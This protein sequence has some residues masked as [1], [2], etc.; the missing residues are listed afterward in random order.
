MTY[1]DWALTIAAV[2]LVGLAFKAMMMPDRSRFW[3]RSRSY[4]YFSNEP[5]KPG[6]D[7]HRPQP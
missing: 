1:G 3:H 5:E 6:E 2:V 4:D 7:A